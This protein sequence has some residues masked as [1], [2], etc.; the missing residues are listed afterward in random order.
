MYVGYWTQQCEDWFQERLRLILAGVEKPLSA[1][2]W[3]DYMRK[4]HNTPSLV[5]ANRTAA[6]NFFK[7]MYAF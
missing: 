3:T 2:K 6:A 1:T 5:A 7:G 4:D